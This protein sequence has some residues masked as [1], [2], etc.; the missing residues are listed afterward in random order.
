MDNRFIYY[1]KQL[2]L[3][4]KIENVNRQKLE[5]LTTLWSTQNYFYN[6]QVLLVQNNNITLCYIPWLYQLSDLSNKENY[7]A[8]LIQYLRT[9]LA[10]Q[11]YID[12]NKCNLIIRQ[13]NNISMIYQDNNIT[14]QYSYIRHCYC[15]LINCLTGKNYKVDDRELDFN[16]NEH[17]RNYDKNT[18]HNYCQ[19]INTLNQPYHLSINYPQHNIE[20][21]ENNLSKHRE[22]I[23]QLFN[24]YLNHYPTA[25]CEVFFLAADLYYQSIY[26]QNNTNIIYL[27]KSTVNHYFSLS[28]D[29]SIELWQILGYVNTNNYYYYVS[30]N[31]KQLILLFKHVLL[32][33]KLVYYH[34]NLQAIQNLLWRDHI[35]HPATSHLGVTMQQFYNL[36]NI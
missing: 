20:D 21:I 3:G 14:N 12:I 26:C 9:L 11:Y 15:Y 36:L 29:N 7:L 32:S 18:R 33:R 30:Y 31:I 6:Y 24:Y 25:L 13:D 28:T 22:N 19:L 10:Q 5:Q 17:F 35:L 2:Y 27:I 23:K 4:V 34:I 8:G 16:I 1:E